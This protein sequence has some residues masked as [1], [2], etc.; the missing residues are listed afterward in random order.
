MHWW[1]AVCAAGTVAVVGYVSGGSGSVGRSDLQCQCMCSG[2]N[3]NCSIW[4]SRLVVMGS[5][6]LN[7]PEATSGLGPALHSSGG[8][9]M[10]VNAS[11]ETPI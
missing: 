11:C 4:W 7:C 2:G 10:S 1:S 9:S 3:L 6:H 8:C 5:L